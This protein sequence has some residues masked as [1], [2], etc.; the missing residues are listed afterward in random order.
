MNAVL[1]GMEDGWAM[2]VLVH[3]QRQRQ[4]GTTKNEFTWWHMI[5]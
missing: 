5:N 1:I 4:V 2:T 3:L